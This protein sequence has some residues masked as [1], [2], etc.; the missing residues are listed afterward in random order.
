MQLL[1]SNIGVAMISS[2]S[3]LKLS[4]RRLSFVSPEEVP[5]TIINLEYLA[6]CVNS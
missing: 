6:Y 2:S 3:G 5:V 1:G 4:Y